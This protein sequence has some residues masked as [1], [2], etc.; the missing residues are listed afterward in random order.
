MLSPISSLALVLA[1]SLTVPLRALAQSPASHPW[2]EAGLEVSTSRSGPRYMG[3]LAP[4]IRAAIA[5]PIVARTL[6]SIDFQD[7]FG[8][9]YETACLGLPGG[10]PCAATRGFTLVGGAASVI[11]DRPSL[12]PHMTAGLGLGAY[13]LRGTWGQ[14]PLVL[15]IP[16]RIQRPIVSGQSGSVEA[17]LHA[18]IIPA[19]DHTS[20][21]S[22]GIGFA[23]RGRVFDGSASS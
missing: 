8:T 6:L 5:V 20:V 21:V 7:E 19:V 9:R 3:D 10:A 15:G 23:F 13:R 18:L 22:F 2:V 17:A 11:A 1:V 14:S 12:L 4:S 16:L